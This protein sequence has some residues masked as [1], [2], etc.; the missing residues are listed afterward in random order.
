M[1]ADGPVIADAF[2][3]ELF[4]ESLPGED[5]HASLVCPNTT[6][7]ARAL[8][9]AVKKLREQKCSFVRWVPFVHFGL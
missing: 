8:D 1:D 4:K 3:G 5:R 6:H 9:F 7:A 2:Y